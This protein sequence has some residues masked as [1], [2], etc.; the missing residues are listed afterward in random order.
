MNR[1][2]FLKTV[3]VGIA[4]AV[5]TPRILISP[6]Q[7]NTPFQGRCL[8][9]DDDPTKRPHEE[10]G[11]EWE[12]RD[13]NIWDIAMDK[14]ENIYVVT[15]ICLDTIHLTAIEADTNPNYLEV[16]QDNFF[17]YFI[18]ISSTYKERP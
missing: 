10:Q 4:A 5:I 9:L 15:A 8:V 11:V 16:D 14:S 12:N 17:E 2:N 3:S 7:I 6:E 13:V 18:I 1:L